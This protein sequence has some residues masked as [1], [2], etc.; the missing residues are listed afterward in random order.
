M[1]SYKIIDETPSNPM[2]SVAMLAYNHENFIVEAIESVLMQKTDHSIQLVIAED[3]S[4]DDTRAILLEFQN[5]FPD[6][7]KLI[8]QNKNVGSQLNNMTLL[9]NLEG[10]Y[11]AALEGDDYWTDPL[12]LQKQ[13]DFLE[14]NIEYSMVCHNAQ[15]IYEGGE[16][17]ET[18]F[19][20]RTTDSEISMQEI[21]NDWTIPTAS[22][23][24]RKK[25][26]E[27]LPKWFGDIYS[28]DFTL[29]LLFR[30]FG[31]V[32]FLNE[33]MSVYRVN[34]SGSS[35]SS[36]YKDSA[37][38]IHN[39]HIK[40]LNYFNNFSNGKYNRLISQRIDFLQN[41]IKFATL[42]KKGVV[43]SFLYMPKLFLT[44]LYKR[45]TIL[46]YKNS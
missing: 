35:A 7:I 45:L 6:K 2:V 31:K 41:E 46:F 38:F 14:S 25:C 36:V 17:K 37:T 28:G 5:K 33:M 12:K 42:K 1:S 3:G 30:H 18:I 19:S 32:F 13:V 27:N 40:L 29:A 4:K 39:E 43:Q 24:F 22:M 11:I 15:I 20:K 23:V 26:I 16:K 8:L 21:L 44:K 10:K 9:T 34:Y